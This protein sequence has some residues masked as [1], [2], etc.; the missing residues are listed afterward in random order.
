MKFPILVDLSLVIITKFVWIM[1]GIREDFQRNN[2]FSLHDLHDHALVQ[3]PC[4]GSHEIYNLV[5]LSSIIITIY[6]VRLFFAREY[7]KEIFKENLHFHYIT[8]TFMATP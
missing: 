8:C 1:P 4:P 3:E 2:A 7:K 6:L 5:D